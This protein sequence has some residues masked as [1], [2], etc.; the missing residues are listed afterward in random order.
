MLF[1]Y[2]TN[3]NVYRKG[4]PALQIVSSRRSIDECNGIVIFMV[5]ANWFSIPRNKVPSDQLLISLNEKPTLFYVVQKN[6]YFHLDGVFFSAATCNN[7]ASDRTFVTIDFRTHYFVH[8]DRTPPS[9][10]PV[11]ENETYFEPMD[12]GLLRFFPPPPSPTLHCS[13]KQ[14]IGPRRGQISIF[15]RLPPR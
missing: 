3:E 11:I 7:R 8:S 6:S 2:L 4:E 9:R 12:A 5:S 1:I 13:V 14:P 15:T 10:F